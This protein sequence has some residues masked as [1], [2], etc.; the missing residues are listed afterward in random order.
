MALSDNDQPGVSLEFRP[1]RSRRRQ[2]HPLV[3]R[4]R[5]HAP[6]R[7]S[8]GSEDGV[9]DVQKGQQNSSE[10]RRQEAGDNLGT[11]S[12][13]ENYEE[14]TNNHALLSTVIGT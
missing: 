3:R 11:T 14:E 7:S 13:L 10:S 2:Q 12:D 9:V 8:T 6:V 4:R 1:G 5:D